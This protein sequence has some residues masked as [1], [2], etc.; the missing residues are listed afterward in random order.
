MIVYQMNVKTAFLNG[1]LKEEVYVLQP[2]GFVDQDHPNY[3]CTLK[4]ALY[5]LKQAPR[6]VVKYQAKPTE[7]HLTT[8]KRVFRYLKGTINMGLWYPKDTRIKLTTYVDA[9]HAGCQDTRRSTF[10]SEQF[11]VDK[12]VSWSLKKQKS[13]AI[14]TTEAEY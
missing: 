13:I 8:I 10:G 9:D 14:S 7:K 6:H 11:L 2:E 3:V 4:K 5:R 12:L 1:V